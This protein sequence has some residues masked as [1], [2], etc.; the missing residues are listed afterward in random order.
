VKE[1]KA[2]EITAKTDAKVQLNISDAND[3]ANK[4]TTRPRITA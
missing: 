3:M 2:A 4:K 1:A